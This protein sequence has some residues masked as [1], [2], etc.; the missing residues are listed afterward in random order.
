MTYSLL[1]VQ[2]TLLVEDSSDAFGEKSYFI[3]GATDLDGF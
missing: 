3:V 2:Q 1:T